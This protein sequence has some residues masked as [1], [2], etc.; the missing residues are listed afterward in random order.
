MSNH[1]PP[2]FNMNKIRKPR[3]S[4]IHKLKFNKLLNKSGDHITIEA[5]DSKGKSAL[6]HIYGNCFEENCFKHFNSATDKPLFHLL[7]D[8]N[9]KNISLELVDSDK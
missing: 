8:E 1:K 2:Y 6:C 7:A 4:L 3:K 5:T 9:A